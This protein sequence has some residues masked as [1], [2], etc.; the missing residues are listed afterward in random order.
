MKLFR[1]LALVVV[2]TAGLLGTM[3]V[4]FASTAS[5]EDYQIGT[6]PGALVHL[7]LTVRALDTKICIDL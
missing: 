2:A 7:C 1:R 5:A 6:P 4:P 3:A